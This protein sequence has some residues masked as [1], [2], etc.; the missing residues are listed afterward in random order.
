M[1]SDVSSGSHFYLDFSPCLGP[2]TE[3]ESSCSKGFLLT[4]RCVCH[5]GAVMVVLE[6]SPCFTMSFQGRTIL[7]AIQLYSYNVTKVGIKHPGAS[8]F[9]KTIQKN[10]SK[11]KWASDRD[12]CPPELGQLLKKGSYRAQHFHHEDQFRIS[13]R[14]KSGPES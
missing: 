3:L 6:A 13:H 11:S 9:Q 4:P 7:T 8:Q 1:T 14:S 5:R 10:K 2:K 12:V